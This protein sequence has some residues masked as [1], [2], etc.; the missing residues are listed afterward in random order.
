MAT[1]KMQ[2][3]TNSSTP[4]YASAV[5]LLYMQY[6][7]TT[8]SAYIHVMQTKTCNGGKLFYIKCHI[9][10][11][12]IYLR[13]IL[14]VVFCFRCM[15][16]SIQLMCFTCPAGKCFCQPTSSSIISIDLACKRSISFLAAYYYSWE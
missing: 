11:K 1:G 7:Y 14:S 2:L 10:E 3:A 12:Y 8:T 6:R 13:F 16:Q 15:W 5:T 4:K 9:I